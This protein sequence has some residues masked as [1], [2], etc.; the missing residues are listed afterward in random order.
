MNFQ[1][2]KEDILIFERSH[3]FFA[4]SLLFLA[5]LLFKNPFSEH[6]LIPNLY[7]YADTIHYINPARSLLAGEGLRI[8]RAGSGFTP[9][10][11]PLYSLLLVPM[12][13]IYNDPRTFYFVNVGLAFV[14]L[15]FFYLIL[16][17]ITK[18]GWIRTMLLLLYV[19][20]LLVHYYPLLAMAENL[21]LPLFLIGVCLLVAE[22]T[23][24]KAFIAGLLSMSFYATKYASAP[25]TISFF[26]LYLVK[27]IFTKKDRRKKA[28]IFTVF[29][30]GFTVFF[31]SFNIYEYTVKNTSVIHTLR[32]YTTFLSKDTAQL[33]SSSQQPVYF[34]FSFFKRNLI[35]YLN[36]L[37][38]KPSII[39]GVSFPIIA[40]FVAIFAWPGFILGF[41][42]RKLRYLSISLVFMLS[43]SILFISTFKTFDA[44]YVYQTI[45]TLFLGFCFLLNLSYKLL[46]R[47]SLE[48][49]FYYGLIGLLLIY[50]GQAELYLTFKEDVDP[51]DYVGVLTL[52]RYFNQ[53]PSP[54]KKE[55][56][57]ISILPPYFVD[58]YSNG[59]YRLLPLSKHQHFFGKADVVWGEDD[60]SNLL[61]LYRSYLN[62]GLDLYV[63]RAILLPM[64]TRYYADYIKIFKNFR[65]TQVMEGCNKECNIYRLSR[66]ED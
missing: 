20:N 49:Y 8:T 13:A 65:L 31:V 26:I 18:N 24:K 21:I 42:S 16:L 9:S 1:Q 63:H 60:Y 37:L 64:S 6:S 39:L 46:Q 41:F 55:P 11:P 10:V 48:R 17:K 52:N 47:L 51:A 32:S 61:T 23:R 59:N 15:A 40:R 66:L 27:T 53:P 44:R 3:G 4:T 5:V 34:S 35:R 29:L 38:G 22:L 30:F 43:T 14:S 45:P 54:G 2:F 12:F 62:Q 50:F 58:Y 7:P 56:I 57:V 28:V 19:T 25:L 33:A 36:L